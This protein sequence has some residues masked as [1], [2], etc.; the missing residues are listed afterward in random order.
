M[1][2]WLYIFYYDKRDEWKLELLRIYLNIRF[3]LSS[4]ESKY[5][6]L[7]FR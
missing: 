5:V 1:D 2:V 6:Y 4:F 3:Y 7:F